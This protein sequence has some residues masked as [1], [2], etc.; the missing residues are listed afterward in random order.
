MFGRSR[1]W[2]AVPTARPLLLQRGGTVAT[3]SVASFSA[4]GRTN[5]GSLPGLARRR[6]CQVLSASPSAGPRSGIHS[7][8][9]AMALSRAMRR[10]PGSRTVTPSG[11]KRSRLRA[12]GDP[13]DLA[14]EWLEADAQGGFAC[15]TVGGERTRRYHALLLVATHPRGGR[16]ILVN[17]IE[18]WV[19]TLD[20]NHPITSQHYTPD[21]V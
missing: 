1:A 3:G 18:A 15:G 20:G 8:A 13:M 14:A 21:V 2:I 16:V 6:Q 19:T 5:Q 12:Q 7:S 11:F 4:A 9:S 17:G 10:W